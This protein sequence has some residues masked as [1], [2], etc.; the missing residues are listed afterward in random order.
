MSKDPLFRDTHI[1]LVPDDKQTGPENRLVVEVTP[2]IRQQF[3]SRG[4]DWNTQT[5]KNTLMHRTIKVQ[6]WLFYDGSHENVSFV[7][8]PENKSG[9][10]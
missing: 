9:H 2:R 6:G 10:N 8:N 4:I 3:A 1:E 5:L 7:Y